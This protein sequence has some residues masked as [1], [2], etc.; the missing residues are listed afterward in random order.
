MLSRL[1]PQ[2]LYCL[3]DFMDFEGQSDEGMRSQCAY[4]AAEIIDV[5]SLDGKPQEFPLD[6]GM[7]L[8]RVLIRFTFQKTDE[9]SWDTETFD[10]MPY[11]KKSEAA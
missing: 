8:G 7:N 11:K 9:E 10:V 6:M 4:E 2:V 5:Y 3:A 1:E